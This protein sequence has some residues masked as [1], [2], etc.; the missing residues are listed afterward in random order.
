M[1]CPKSKEFFGVNTWLLCCEYH[2]DSKM[3]S[4]D[5]VWRVAHHPRFA[6]VLKHM[7]LSS[8]NL[9]HMF[10]TYPFHSNATAM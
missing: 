7:M 1:K 2:F 9:L 4:V 10:I 3:H 5:T 8:L 6:C